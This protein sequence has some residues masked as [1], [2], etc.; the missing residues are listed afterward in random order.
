MLIEVAD[1]EDWGMGEVL[2]E[3]FLELIDGGVG[4]GDVI[5]VADEK[6]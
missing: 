6:G 5:D 2:F 4:L 1:E 3:V